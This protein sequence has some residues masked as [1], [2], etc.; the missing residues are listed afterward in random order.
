[1]R[2]FVGAIPNTMEQ[3]PPLMSDL[4]L[5]LILA[6]AVSLIF[7]KLKQP[8]V[9]GYIVAGF[10]AGKHMPYMPSVE[11]A[12]GVETWSQIGV[13]FLMFTLGLEFSFKKII[14]QGPGPLITALL[15]MLSM[16]AVGSSL[17]RL[18]GWGGMDCLFLGGMLAM[19][20][21]TI[22]FKAFSDLGLMQKTFA[23]RVLSVLVLEDILGILLMVV[24]S[25]MAVSQTLEGTELMGSLLELG[26]FLILWF[27]VGI[28]L[29]PTIL[30]RT[31]RLMNGETLLIVSIACC[32][33]LVVI[34]A[35]VGYSTAF[36]A[37]MMGSILAETVEAERIEKLVGP[38]KDLF[39]AIFFVSVGMLVDPHILVAYWAPILVLTLGILLGQA[40]LG[41]ASFLLTGHSFRT[42][43]QCGFS[44]AQVGEFAF[45]IASMGMAMGVTSR[46]L[47]PVIVAVSIVTTF[48]T[49]YMIRYSQHLNVP[50][51]TLRH[52]LLHSRGDVSESPWR[53]LLGAIGIQSSVYVVL[54]MAV[55]VVAMSTIYPLLQAMLPAPSSSIVGGLVCVALVSPFLRPIVMRKN[56]SAEWRTLA[57]R[58]QRNRVLLTM[59]LVGRFLLCAFFVYNIVEYVSVYPIYWNIPIALVLTLMVCAS[60]GVK[61]VSRRLEAAF[62]RNLSA[63]EVRP[64]S[65]ENELQAFSRLITADAEEREAPIKLRHLRVEA[66]MPFCGKPLRDSRLREDFGCQVVGLQDT[67]DSL[68]MPDAD[69]ALQAG[70]VLWV[71]GEQRDLLRLVMLKEPS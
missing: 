28:F 25:G 2:N 34:A 19:S 49:P 60:K 24:L 46:F 61:R 68:K 22:I 65:A 9:L 53:Q 67:D 71:V 47:Y 40:V 18:F 41:T 15:V 62:H 23:P 44:L 6:G 52:P 66:G 63:R 50:S 39:G 55:S 58:S 7:K 27:V 5:I 31:K 35:K 42:S 45:I 3:I 32:F 54:T 48:L 59:L 38:V 57:A 43:V 14:K 69:Y 21:T 4:A 17:G 12:G 29:I 20:S 70:D 13:I 30:R 8:L 36:G 10:L 56:H 33:L 64:A 26:F 51:I 16:M 1:M 11:D 37:F